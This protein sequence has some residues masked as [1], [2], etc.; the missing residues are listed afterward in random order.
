MQ[1][2]S[3]TARSEGQNE[4]RVHFVRTP[5]MKPFLLVTARV[6]TFTISHSTSSSSLLQLQ[7][8]TPLFVLLLSLPL[9]QVLHLKED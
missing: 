5:G 9:P 7:I 6:D 3:L 2:S 8:Q 4:Q 1:A